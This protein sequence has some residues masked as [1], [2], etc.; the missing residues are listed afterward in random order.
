ME[1]AGPV[2]FSRLDLGGGEGCDPLAFTPVPVRARADGW[3]AERQQKFV[4]LLAAGCGPSEAAQAV[5]KSK[6]SAFVLRGRAGAQS[7]AAAWDAAVGLA[8]GR[9]GAGQPAGDHKRAVEGVLVPRFYRGRLVSVER[10]FPHGSLIRLMAQLQRWE[11]RA[12]DSAHGAPSFEELLDAIA[13]PAPLPRRRRRRADR[14][15]LDR[16]FGRDGAAAGGA[17]PK[18]ETPEVDRIHGDAV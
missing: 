12:G 13:P 4:H 3:T 1:Q 15:A 10:R 8:Q 5:G 11:P 17:E 2:D 7:F 9:R 18:P 14:A 6:Q 16:R